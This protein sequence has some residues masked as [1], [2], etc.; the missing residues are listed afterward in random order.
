MAK[1]RNTVS[2][3]IM[4]PSSS[5]SHLLCKKCLR[6]SFQSVQDKKAG[7]KRIDGHANAFLLDGRRVCVCARVGGQIKNTSAFEGRARRRLL[8]NTIK[9]VQKVGG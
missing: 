2:V 9:L 4:I 7:T 3:R 8:T 5:V 1:Q 6:V